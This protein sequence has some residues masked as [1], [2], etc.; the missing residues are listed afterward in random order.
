MWADLQYRILK[1]AFPRGPGFGESTFY[2]GK[3]K[4]EVVLGA[5][6]L[7]SVAGKTVIDFGCGEGSEAIE[8]A[9]SGAERVLGLDYREDVL[10]IARR[11]AQ[12]AAVDKICEFTQST[13]EVADIIISIDAFEHFDDPAAILRTMDTLLTPDG[14]IVAAFGPTWYHPLGGHSFSIFPWSPR[15]RRRRRVTARPP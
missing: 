8:I 6:F 12:E 1:R 3:S 9:R 15:S 13:N 11:K 4:A 7:K 5:G 2:I 10:Q 14:S